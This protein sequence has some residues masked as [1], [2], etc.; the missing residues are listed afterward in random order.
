MPTL[1]SLNLFISGFSMLC[2]NGFMDS[3]L[4]LEAPHVC[5]NA[6]F[7]VWVRS[8]C[9]LNYCNPKTPL[10]NVSS[11]N[12]ELRSRARVGKGPRPSPRS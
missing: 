11:I 9:L 12:P 2:V 7:M 4:G 5:L 8:R 6:G 10:T 3:E 1:M